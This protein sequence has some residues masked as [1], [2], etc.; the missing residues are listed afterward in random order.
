MEG[1]KLIREWVRDGFGGTDIKRQVSIFREYRNMSLPEEYLKESFWNGVRHEAES[2]L[3]GMNDTRI[4]LRYPK[5]TQSGVQYLP[6]P[7]QTLQQL[8]ALW[9]CNLLPSGVLADRLQEEFDCHSEA[10]RILRVWEG[11]KSREV[12]P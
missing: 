11:V 8:T 2:L 5:G 1:E 6:D 12:K 4:R 7:S 9:I 10:A 3:V